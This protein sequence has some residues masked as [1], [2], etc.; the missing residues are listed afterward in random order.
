MVTQG[1]LAEQGQKW[2]TAVSRVRPAEREQILD[3]VAGFLE[4]KNAFSMKLEASIPISIKDFLEKF[5]S[6]QINRELV[7]TAIGT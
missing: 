2:S 3:A 6:G 4:V 5:K 1:R 7:V